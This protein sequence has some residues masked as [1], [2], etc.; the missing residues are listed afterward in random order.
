MGYPTRMT[1]TA[2]VQKLFVKLA[3]PGT[4]VRMPDR[5]MHLLPEEGA[6]V[7][8]SSFWQARLLNGDVV[9]ATPPSE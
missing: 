3:V 8:S 2:P 6:W 4:A 7:V 5:N 9:E 1:V